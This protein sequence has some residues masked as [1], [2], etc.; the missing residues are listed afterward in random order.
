MP[1]PPIPIPILVEASGAATIFD[2]VPEGLP[3]GIDAL[4]DL[5]ELV[6]HGVPTALG[7]AAVVGGEA[8]AGGDGREGKERRCSRGKRNGEL[9]V[10]EGEGWSADGSHEREEIE[11]ES[12][13]NGYACQ[14]VCVFEGD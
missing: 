10:R 2:S 9:L 13:R 14:S 1:A 5:G 8:A 4:G 6:Q 11:K 3:V 7:A 12:E